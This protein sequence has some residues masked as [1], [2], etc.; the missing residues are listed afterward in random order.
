MTLNSLNGYELWREA[1]PTLGVIESTLKRL[2]A[3]LLRK[4][5]VR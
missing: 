3:L 1:A 4:S 2:N 5:Q